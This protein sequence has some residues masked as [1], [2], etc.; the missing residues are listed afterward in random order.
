[1]NLA[2]RRPMTLRRIPRGVGG[3]EGQPLRYG[4][5]PDGFGLVA[6]TGGGRTATTTIQ[7]GILPSPWTVPP[8]WKA[9][10]FQGKATFKIQVGDKEAISVIPTGDES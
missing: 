5:I 9:V 10:E 4:K 6:M 8:T 3:R 7:R 2:L 1:M